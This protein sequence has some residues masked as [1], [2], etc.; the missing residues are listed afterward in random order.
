MD[1]KQLISEEEKISKEIINKVNKLIKVNNDI[2]LTCRYDS[3]LRP[4]S[5]CSRSKISMLSGF[6]NVLNRKQKYRTLLSAIE[7]R[8]QEDE[9]RRK[10]RRSEAKEK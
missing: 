8:V 5:V 10:R 7:E 4:I 3:D 6:Q 2:H 9:K 1:L